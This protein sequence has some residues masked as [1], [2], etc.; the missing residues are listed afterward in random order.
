MI[1]NVGQYV[2]LIRSR[3]VNGVVFP[4]GTECKVAN[5]QEPCEYNGFIEIYDVTVLGSEDYIQCLTYG[6]ILAMTPK[7]VAESAFFKF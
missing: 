6:D 1:N 4:V 7:E 5:I 3:L 2:R